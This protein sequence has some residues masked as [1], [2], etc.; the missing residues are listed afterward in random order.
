MFQ[1]VMTQLLVVAADAGAIPKAAAAAL[2]ATVAATAAVRRAMSFLTGLA[3]ETELAD[4]A[5][6]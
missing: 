1:P 2:A 4:M 3:A 6:P 5:T